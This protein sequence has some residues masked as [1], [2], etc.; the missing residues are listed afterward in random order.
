MPALKFFDDLASD[1]TIK[2]ENPMDCHVHGRDGS[3]KA[4]V[5]PHT[6]RTMS[7]AIFMP[8]L[9]GNPIDS[10]AKAEAYIAN[11][12]DLDAFVLLYLNKN[13]TIETVREVAASRASDRPVAIG[14]KWYP[15][16][17]TVNSN[18]SAFRYYTE[19]QHLLAE[20]EKLG[21]PLS[22][23]PESPDPEIG[24]LE[25]EYYFMEF[26]FKDIRSIYP[27]L[28]IILEHV[29]TLSGTSAVISNDNTYGT[30]TAHHSLADFNDLLGGKL[31]PH[32]F[33]KPILQR[34]DTR[35]TLL[36]KLLWCNDPPKK[37]FLGTDSAPHPMEDKES[38][39]IPGGCYTAPYTL[40]LYLLAFIEAFAWCSDP[41]DVN[42]IQSAFQAF[43]SFGREVY[44]LPAPS[45]NTSVTI[46]NSPQIIAHSYQIAD[47]DPGFIVPAFAGERLQFAADSKK[48]F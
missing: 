2:L 31:N 6:A 9:A 47:K 16:G 24:P 26:S 44:K 33:C 18:E 34:S 11:I 37:F 10:V 41:I 42:E 13:T 4:T 28:T 43:C 12:H 40:E 8:N 32:M 46:R 25:R 38:D 48:P 30:I 20:M 15:E 19:F 27:E 21:V 3:I 7:Q 1:F 45:K 17:V 29:S 14:F 22:I 35:K 36:N 39:S 5:V 23:H